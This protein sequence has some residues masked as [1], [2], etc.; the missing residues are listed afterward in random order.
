MSVFKERITLLHVIS[1]ALLHTVLVD[2]VLCHSCYLSDVGIPV[3]VYICMCLRA[4]VNKFVNMYIQTL[5]YVNMASVFFLKNPV[6][7]FDGCAIC[8]T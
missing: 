2:Y 3:Y 4:Y 8:L 6:T 5:L 1:S 7:V